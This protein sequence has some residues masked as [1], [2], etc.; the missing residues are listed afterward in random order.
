MLQLLAALVFVSTVYSQDLGVPL[1]WRKFSND[2]PL[3][4]RISIAQNGIN[5]IL[6]QL[7]SSTAEFTGEQY[8]TST[9]R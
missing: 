4:E 6:P 8:G 2:R 5:E 1:S 7:D 3:E 9:S